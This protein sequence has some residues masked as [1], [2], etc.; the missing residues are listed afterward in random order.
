LDVLQ[1]G[2][3]KD[4]S[5]TLLN[6]DPNNPSSSSSVGYRMALFAQLYVDIYTVNVPVS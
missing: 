1:I 2:K 3:A 5:A 6:P 4:L